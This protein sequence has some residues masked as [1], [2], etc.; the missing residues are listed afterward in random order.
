MVK[1]VQILE[2]KGSIAQDPKAFDSVLSLF[3]EYDADNKNNFVE[4]V[5]LLLKYL[6]N[7]LSQYERLRPDALFAIWLFLKL[8]QYVFYYIVIVVYYYIHLTNYQQRYDRVA[9][10][11]IDFYNIQRSLARLI[12]H[13]I[14]AGTVSYP[15][16][17]AIKNNNPFL[18]NALHYQ[19]SAHNCEYAP[20]GNKF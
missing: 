18:F 10:T 6:E 8:Q 9:R 14:V 17:D 12:A 11:S 1:L 19:L 2:E 4:D 13:S 5:K 20:L 15:S 16:V 7:W 3:T